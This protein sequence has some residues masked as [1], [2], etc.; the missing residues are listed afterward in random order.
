MVRILPV[1]YRILYE[2]SEFVMMKR[3][4]KKFVICY[5]AAS[6]PGF[7][8]KSW[9]ITSSFSPFSSSL[10]VDE[11]FDL[12]VV[13][14]EP[15]N[16]AR[17]HSF[18]ALAEFRFN[19]RYGNAVSD[20]SDYTFGNRR[21]RAVNLNFPEHFHVRRL[22]FRS[23]DRLPIAEVFFI[24]SDLGGLSFSDKRRDGPGNIFSASLGNVDVTGKPES[25]A[26]ILLGSGLIGAAGFRKRLG[27]IKEAF[28][29]CITRAG[30]DFKS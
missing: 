4:K 5:R 21:F 26:V 19:V 16:G 29:P 10:D 27:K 22:G 13:I 6:G 7:S 2:P 20:F 8:D 15:G 1:E 25:A 9:G 18:K 3:A 23:P 30:Y 24:G 28:L 14:S 11:P 17:V 12:D